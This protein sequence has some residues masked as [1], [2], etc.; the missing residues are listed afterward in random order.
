MLLS[1]VI[2]FF[3]FSPATSL[4]CYSC[5]SSTTNEECN[6]KSETCQ[7]PLDTCMTIVDTLGYM[8]AIVKQCASSSTCKGA[9]STAS[10]D[11]DGNGNTINCCSYDM[12]NMSAADSVHSHTALLL[13]TGA[14]L[15]L[16]TH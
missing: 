13:L 9:A 16:L 7:Q 10:V 3:L 2:L 11:A 8:K 1:F 14:V 6:Q 5:G 12:C 4:Q 15:L